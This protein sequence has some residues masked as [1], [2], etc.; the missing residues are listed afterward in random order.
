[1]MRLVCHK[2]AP[3]SSCAV[4]TLRAAATGRGPA[5]SRSHTG[6]AGG[7]ASVRRSCGDVNATAY[8]LYKVLCD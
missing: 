6:A 8:D 1:M 7:R 3:P 5:T 2:L 4:P